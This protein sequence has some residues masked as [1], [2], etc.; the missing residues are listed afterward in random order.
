ME[1]VGAAGGEYGLSFKQ[2]PDVVARIV[3]AAIDDCN[4]R[5]RYV[6]G[7]DVHPLI[8]KHGTGPRQLSVRDEQHVAI[9]ADMSED[10]FLAYW[11]EHYGV[12]MGVTRRGG[13]GFLRAV[14]RLSR[15]KQGLDGP[16]VTPT[17][18]S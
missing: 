17:F 18:T 9:G 4:S 3:A 7:A 14:A 15:S 11:R 8:G 16:R 10:E 5:L 2:G 6:A 13:G 1:C 12:D